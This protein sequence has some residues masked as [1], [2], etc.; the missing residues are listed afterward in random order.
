MQASGRPSAPR[1]DRLQPDDAEEARKLVLKLRWIGMEEEARRLSETLD[2]GACP[3]V[4]P[5]E[6]D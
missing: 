6:T 2:S 1:D 5:R 3:F 4:E